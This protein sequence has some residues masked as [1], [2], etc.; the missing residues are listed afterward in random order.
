MRQN[1]Q[2]IFC[3]KTQVCLVS[4]FP[5]AL[6]FWNGHL[7]CRCCIFGRACLL[8]VFFQCK[9]WGRGRALPDSSPCWVPPHEVAIIP[10]KPKGGRLHPRRKSLYRPFIVDYLFLVRK[11]IQKIVEFCGQHIMG[12]IY[13]LTVNMGGST[14]G[15]ANGHA[16]RQQATLPKLGSSYLRE[17]SS[18]TQSLRRRRRRR[19]S[20]TFVKLF[21]FL[22][23]RFY[24]WN[25]IP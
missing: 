9:A 13:R 25:H 24:S 12:G 14:G 20:C 18:N 4:W 11:E 7:H 15:P 21:L 10:V 5:S 1:L 8:L 2:S 19:S 3:L 16:H 17:T 22:L 6:C 23:R